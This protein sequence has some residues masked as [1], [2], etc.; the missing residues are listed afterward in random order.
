MMVIMLGMTVPAEKKIRY[1]LPMIPAACLLTA[2]LFIAPREQKYFRIVR[3]IMLY[4]LALLPTFAMVA[5]YFYAPHLD[6][7]VKQMINLTQINLFF[8]C[9]QL[10]LFAQFIFIRRYTAEGI[11]VAAVVTL[12]TLNYAL[13]EPIKLYVERAHD[14]VHQ[15]EAIRIKH[16]AYLVFYRE[17]ADAMP[18][19]YMMNMPTLER[20]IF[21]VDE[22]ALNHYDY[23]SY[24]ISSAE[25]IRTLA[26]STL[27]KYHI[28]AQAILGHVPVYA[29]TNVK[30]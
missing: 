3:Q 9:V 25:N 11:L 20:P 10:A 19:K 21:M 15:I 5:A 7:A 24:F 14:F 27:A 8:I 13:L 17:R 26:P 2:Y 28:I 22:L 6:P 16:H 23:P 4:F 1:I 30:D 12:L 29:F 18:I